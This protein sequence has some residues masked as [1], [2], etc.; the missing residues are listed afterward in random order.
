MKTLRIGLFHPQKMDTQAS[1]WEETSMGVR[2]GLADAPHELLLNPL[3]SRPLDGALFFMPREEDLRLVAVAEQKIPGIVMSGFSDLFPSVDVENFG[4]ACSMMER[5]L[6]LG[7]RRIAFINGSMSTAHGWNRFRGYRDSLLKRGIPLEGKWVVT[8][9]DRT[10]D[11]Y[12]AMKKLLGL[13]RRPT[14]VVCAHDTLA[15][16]ALKAAQ[17]AG[18]AV[19]EEVAVVGFEDIPEAAAHGLTTFHL[20]FRDIAR[21]AAN[22][23]L[24]S[25]GHA[26]P[27]LPGRHTVTGELIIRESDRFNIPPLLLA[28]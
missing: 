28:K 17:D 1:P 23:L 16:S 8:S 13:P 5:L 6:G 4:A 19:P 9:E 11:A 25:I 20:P 15:I 21:K 10:S 7:H 3:A 18:V 24:A 22:E 2:E 27:I 12:F 14:A 26:P